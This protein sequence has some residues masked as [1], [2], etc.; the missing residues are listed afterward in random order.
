M[1]SATDYSP[2]AQQAEFIAALSVLDHVGR[3][4]LIGQITDRDGQHV[5][6]DLLSQTIGMANSV[7]A[8]CREWVET[9]AIVRLDMHPHQAEQINTPSMLGAAMGARIAA[10][11][12]QDGLCD[13]CAARRGTMANQCAPTVAD[14]DWCEGKGEFLCHLEGRDHRDRPTKPCI[15]AVRWQAVKR[16]VNPDA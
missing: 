3:I 4:E 5:L 1:D 12:D 7:A 2:S 6:A 14:V 9:E 15:G 8:N 10:R 11:V 16:M 13:G